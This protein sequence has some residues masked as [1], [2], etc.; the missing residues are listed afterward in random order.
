MTK[1]KEISKQLN[2]FGHTDDREFWEKHWIGMPEYMMQN[3]EAKKQLK[4]N[5]LTDEH[6]EDFC[7]LIGQKLT[8][9]TKSIWFPATNKVKSITKAYVDKETEEEL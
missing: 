2:L 5:F 4:V 3:L 8:P 9:N 6:Y 1:D 7:K